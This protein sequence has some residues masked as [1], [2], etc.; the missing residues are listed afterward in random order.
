MSQGAPNT[1][2][3]AMALPEAGRVGLARLIARAL[4]RRCPLCGE[5][6]IWA[7]WGQLRP[8]C[9]NCDFPFERASGYWVGAIIVNTAVTEAIF[10]LVFIAVLV[11][12]WP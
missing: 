8:R 9:P 10:G 6:Q 7:S 2:C 5:K 4:R 1:A 3:R 11:L 12:T